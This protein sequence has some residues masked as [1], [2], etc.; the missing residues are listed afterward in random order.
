MRSETRNQRKEVVQELTATFVHARIVS[1]NI[2]HLLHA[3]AS[4]TVANVRFGS[5]PV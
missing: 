4:V 5:H 1:E 2:Q 3:A